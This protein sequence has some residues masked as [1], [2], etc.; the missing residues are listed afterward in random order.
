MRDINFF[1]NRKQNGKNNNGWD[2]ITRAFGLIQSLQGWIQGKARVLCCYNFFLIVLLLNL[3]ACT[4]VSV[5]L[6]HSLY[7]PPILFIYFFFYIIIHPNI[8]AS[9]TLVQSFFIFFLYVDV[10][11][12]S[13]VII[14]SFIS[15]QYGQYVEQ[16]YCSLAFF[17]NNHKKKIQVQ[18]KIS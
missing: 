17:V 16:S 13:S 2:L 10:C 14:V 12:I 7:F 18:I 6:L 11:Q 15:L 4:V 9:F 5:T 1:S 3:S 8:A